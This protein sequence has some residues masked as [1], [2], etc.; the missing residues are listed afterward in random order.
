MRRKRAP[1]TVSNVLSSKL[2]PT[3]T[4]HYLTK[5]VD[6]EGEAYKEAIR[7]V[8]AANGGAHP[9]VH[10][11]TQQIE[12]TASELMRGKNIATRNVAKPFLYND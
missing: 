10:M 4:N 12:H 7:R 1:S 9:V 2:F 6:V 3:T 5:E 11:F 8:V